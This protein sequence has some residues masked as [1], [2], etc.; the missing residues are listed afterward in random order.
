MNRASLEEVA[1]TPRWP[2]AR[3]LA[4]PGRLRG[5]AFRAWGV[6]LKRQVGERAP[7]Q[8][9]AALGM[10]AD[11]LPD[12][13]TR[14]HWYPVSLQCRLIQ[15]VI[16]DLLGGEPMRFQSIF[17]E[18]TGTAERALVLAGRMTGPGLVLR[19]AGNFH[20]TVCDVGRCTPEVG[21]GFATLAF[22]GAEVF[23]EPTWR[24]ANMMSM[25]TMFSSLKRELIELSADALEPQSFRIHMR[26]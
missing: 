19:M 22:S 4:L 20:A 2:A 6:H 7:D 14:A 25:K 10:T 8:V 12:V 16:D 5:N 15:V 11:E 1:A 9:R 18:S 21:S 3:T 17:E 13:P 26:W 23:E 24:F